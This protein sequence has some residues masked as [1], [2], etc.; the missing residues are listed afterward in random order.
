ML[1]FR[2]KN[3]YPFED[4]A[5]QPWIVY[6]DIVP[7]FAEIA[8]VLNVYRHE[9]PIWGDT[10]FYRRYWPED[11]ARSILVLSNQPP[12]YEGREDKYEARIHT[13]EIVEFPPSRP[14]PVQ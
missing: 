13:H 1:F 6:D 8:A 4:Y 9:V 14:H 7:S 10:R 2:A 5:G 3:A 11:Q 12:E